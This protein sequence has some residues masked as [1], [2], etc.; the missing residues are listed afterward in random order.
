MIVKLDTQKAL[1]LFSGGQDSTTCL[2]WALE[3][4]EAV[5]TV[6]FDYGQRHAVE[7]EARPRVLAA[8]RAGFPQWTAKL[9]QDHVLPLGVLKAIGGSA[10]T[11]DMKIEMGEHGL[12]TSFV[13][14]RNVLFLTAAA[15][16]AYRRGIAVLV[17]GMCETDYSGYPDCRNETIK[18][19]E[20]A[21]DLAMEAPFRIE[22]PLMW[23]DKAET[24]A[25]AEKLGGQALVDLIVEETVT[26]Y[27]GERATRHDWGYGCGVC[28]ACE[29]RAKGY[30]NYVSQ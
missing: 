29:L 9:G 26:C 24:W 19:L 2:A 1:V 17:G 21:L 5:E 15:A 27:H 14:G 10:L 28:P 7:L 8:L 25:L 20:A 6:G 4:F 12:P 22:T 30:A 13:P 11:D 18:T 16:L 23:L 3:R